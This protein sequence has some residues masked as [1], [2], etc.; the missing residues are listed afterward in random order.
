M[1][2]SAGQNNWVF[3]GNKALTVDA[4]TTGVL[5]IPA[6]DMLQV[7]YTITGYSV[8][9]FAGFAF[10]NPVDSG[11][12]GFH[13]DRHLFAPSGTNVLSDVGEIGQTA[14]TGMSFR[15]AG[16]STIQAQT[17]VMNITTAGSLKGVTIN[18]A[19]AGAGATP[20]MELPGVGYV[21][22]VSSGINSIELLTRG[23]NNMLAGTGF[24][25]FG[26]NIG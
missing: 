25:V 26:C 14:G 22:T 4:P 1:A 20:P 8:A 9:D 3:L 2:T 18:N 13:C 23:G 11:F 6:M 16:F 21:S 10:N 5:D 12:G 7:S 15:V 17:G 19:T 24:A